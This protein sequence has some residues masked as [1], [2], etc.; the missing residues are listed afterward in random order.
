MKI[1]KNGTIHEVTTD[2]AFYVDSKGTRHRK[3]DCMILPDDDRMVA[4]TKYDKGKAPWYLF[5]MKA[6]EEVVKVLAF[7]AYT[8]GYGENNWMLVKNP[9]KR[10]F[11]ACLR[12][13]SALQPDNPQGIPN[14]ASKDPESGLFH[15]AHAACCLIFILG[16][17]V[18]GTPEKETEQ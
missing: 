6:G 12:H 11:S 14:F 1:I 13:L 8:K 15:V 7:G 10:Y 3:S 16:H 4:G 5:P 18:L 2:G 9:Y 17:L